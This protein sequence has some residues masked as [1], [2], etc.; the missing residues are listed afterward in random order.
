MVY[1]MQMRKTL[2]KLLKKIVTQTKGGYD[3]F[4]DP[5]ESVL[6]NVGAEIKSASASSLLEEQQNKSASAS[7]LLEEQQNKSASAFASSVFQAEQQNIRELLKQFRS[8]F[9]ERFGVSELLSTEET[10]EGS[11]LFGK[12][13]SF[14]QNGEKFIGA[15]SSAIGAVHRGIHTAVGMTGGG[16]KKQ[17]PPPKGVPIPIFKGKAAA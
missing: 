1:T 17:G 6:D 11:F 14:L 7:S 10:E 12:N 13:S 2:Q 5:L 4:S 8:L 9:H 15:V 16:H 3:G